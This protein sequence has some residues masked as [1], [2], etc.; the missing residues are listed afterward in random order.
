MLE[1]TYIH[2]RAQ[3]IERRNN[4]L[5]FGLV[6]IFTLSLTGLNSANKDIA[7]YNE[8]ESRASQAAVRTCLEEQRKTPNGYLIAPCPLTT[9]HKS[10]LPLFLLGVPFIT[11]VAYAAHR[12]QKR[13]NATYRDACIEDI[14]EK[15][16]ESALYS[17]AIVHPRGFYE[18]NPPS[19]DRPSDE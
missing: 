17:T 16:R 4:Y 6:G 19:S 14:I 7:K 1:T 12:V 8:L 9:E 3:R 2:E 18:R 11:G 10:N 15:T 5:F 13:N